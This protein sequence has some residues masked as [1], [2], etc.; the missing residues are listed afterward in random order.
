MNAVRTLSCTVCDLMCDAVLTV[1]MGLVR[2]TYLKV[3]LLK[4]ALGRWRAGLSEGGVE[5]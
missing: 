3:S 2:G 4:V 1:R 5:L